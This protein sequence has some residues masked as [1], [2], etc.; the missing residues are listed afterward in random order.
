MSADG[1]NRAGRRHG[2]KA[3]PGARTQAAIKRGGGRVLSMAAAESH[4]GIPASQLRK[5]ARNGELRVVAIPGSKRFYFLRDDLDR[6]VERW[7]EVRA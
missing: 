4:S 5:L 3:A 2:G 6:A 1:L 7:T